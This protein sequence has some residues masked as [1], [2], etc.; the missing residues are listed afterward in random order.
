MTTE[1]YLP[2]RTIT[3]G[4]E[5]TEFLKWDKNPPSNFGSVHNII[6][7]LEIQ[8]VQGLI[9]FIT[10]G[11]INIKINN[12]IKNSADSYFHSYKDGKKSISKEF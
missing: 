10:S 11:T 7:I 2:A 6:Y 8:H 5:M 3:L 4:Y 9:W 12:T 1:Q